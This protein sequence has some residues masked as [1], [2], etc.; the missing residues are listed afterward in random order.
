MKKKY[1]ILP[2]ILP[3][4]IILIAGCNI[5]KPAIQSQNINENPASAMQKIYNDFHGPQLDSTNTISYFEQ[6]ASLG[7][8]ESLFTQVMVNTTE[9]A[10]NKI[11]PFNSGREQIVFLNIGVGEAQQPGYATSIFYRQNGAYGAIINLH[12]ERSPP[13][14]TPLIFWKGYYAFPVNHEMRHVIRFFK[15]GIFDDHQTNMDLDSSTVYEEYLE[16]ILAEHNIPSEFNSTFTAEEID[17][18]GVVLETD[19][20]LEI[21]ENIDRI[22][23]SITLNQLKYDESM[24]AIDVAP[25]YLEQIVL[26]RHL[27]QAY[28]KPSVQRRNYSIDTTYFDNLN[29]RSRALEN[30]LYQ[31]YPDSKTAMQ[32]LEAIYEEEADKAIMENAK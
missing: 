1:W 28:A 5:T 16:K 17:E 22:L 25:I 18:L 14:T 11:K 30:E 12:L 10:A 31:A 4:L 24:G 19:N 7:W 27:S 3:A 29:L 20:P 15:A 32:S 21:A 26:A 23:N 2:F 6:I 13:T 9:L 8:N